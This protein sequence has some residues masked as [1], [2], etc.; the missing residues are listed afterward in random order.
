MPEDEPLGFVDSHAHIGDPAF[1]PDRGAVLERAWEAGCA[2]IVC[3]G[4]S[5]AAAERARLIAAEHPDRVTWTA[6]VHP[7]DA[8]TFDATRDIERLR[9]FIALGASALGECGLDYHYDNSPRD[10]QREVF[11]HHIDLARETGR[12]LVVHTRA[13]EADT[14]A[15]VRE[16]GSGGVRG[17]LH[18]FS[19]GP[20]LA[21][22]GLEAGWYVSFAGVVTFKKWSGDDLI[23]MVPDD[24]LL[25]ESDAPY[26]TPV[27][28]RGKRNE[29]AFVAHT[30]RRL[31]AV[32]ATTP[33]RIAQL[34]CA[35]AT[36][37]FAF[38]PVL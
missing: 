12:P 14:I 2:A 38:T 20:S 34:V 32:R 16:A 26:L 27:P 13:A 3:I 37:L 17:V 33:E 9:E 35:N 15:A 23:T 7:H 1:D 29:P 25:A 19:G 21:E 10:V 30:V 36:R 5:L 11:R 8:S 31:A 18:C 4:E 28:F 6:G 24:R 22:A